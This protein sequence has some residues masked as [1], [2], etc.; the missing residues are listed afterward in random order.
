MIDWTVHGSTDAVADSIRR[1]SARLRLGD[2][3]I[4]VSAVPPDRNDQRSS[5]DL[6][7]NIR[8]AVIRFDPTLPP[9]QVERQIVHELL[10]VRTV[11][12]ED[13]FDQVVGSDGTAQTWWTRE[14]ESMIEAM[15]DALLPDQPRRDYRGGGAAYPTARWP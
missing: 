9:D 4:G 6:D 14:H 8:R 7:M 3:T 12:L 5:I 2:W 1:W 13:V 10:H 11:G 15:V